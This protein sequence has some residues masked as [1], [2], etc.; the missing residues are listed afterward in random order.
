MLA[1]GTP[2]M[3]FILAIAP[4]P[5]ARVSPVGFRLVSGFRAVPV[6]DRVISVLALHIPSHRKAITRR[7][8][9]KGHHR[10]QGQSICYGPYCMCPYISNQLHYSAL[11]RIC[12]K[13]A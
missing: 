5:G 2:V 12:P 4:V 8:H 7:G 3:L 13:S 10:A 11:L 6:P 9:Q 1:I